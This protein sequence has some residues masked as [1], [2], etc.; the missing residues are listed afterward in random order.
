MPEAWD[1]LSLSLA[2]GVR[3]LELRYPVHEY[4]RTL[5]AGGDATPPDARPTLLVVSRLDYTVHHNAVSE[6]QFVL[7]KALEQGTSLSAA[8]ATAS[9]HF[10][11]DLDL[12]AAQLHGWFAWFA[13]ERL[14][15]NAGLTELVVPT[16]PR[17]NQ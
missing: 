16:S 9:G 4:Y 13:A 6:P 2:P 14:L 5:R 7:L 11:G 10:S 8:I 1:S 17:Y 3:L 12:F 15:Q